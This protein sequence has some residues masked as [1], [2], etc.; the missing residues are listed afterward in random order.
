MM[1]R[2]SRLLLPWVLLK[3][4]GIE[5]RRNNVKF[6]LDE[7]SPAE[8]LSP[9]FEVANEVVAWEEK[10]SASGK[11]DSDIGSS[12]IE[13]GVHEQERTSAQQAAVAEAGARDKKEVQ[14]S[15]QENSAGGQQ[16]QPVSAEVQVQEDQAS[17]FIR[18]ADAADLAPRGLATALFTKAKDAVEK[19]VDQVDEEGPTVVLQSDVTEGA[20]QPA[21]A[22]AQQA[23]SNKT[24][25]LKEDMLK[26]VGDAQVAVS[27]LWDEHVV[28]LGTPAVCVSLGFLAA[29]TTVLLV[30]A[31]VFCVKPIVAQCLPRWML[32]SREERLA[33]EKALITGA[34][35]KAMQE[36]ND[37][38][39]SASKMNLHLRG[40]GGH[41]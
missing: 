12:M 14:Q 25:V 32:T 4:T 26:L 13:R 11:E 33:E 20:A 5:G 24:R 1:I 21:Q 19:W 29:C 15:V 31:M 7:G 6:A 17:H 27:A 38:V 28:A 9:E 18:I 22:E 41:L 37:N 36:W 34:K 2:G 40:F 39:L 35:Q 8:N 3:F 30:L 16:E 23:A 10:P